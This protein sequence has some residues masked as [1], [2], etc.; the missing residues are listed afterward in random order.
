VEKFL[1]M[2]RDLNVKFVILPADFQPRPEI[3]PVLETKISR[4]PLQIA[5]IRQ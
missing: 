3:L 1:R 4:D 5:A 2:S